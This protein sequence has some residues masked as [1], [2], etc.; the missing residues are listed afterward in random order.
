MSGGGYFA[1]LSQSCSTLNALNSKRSKSGYW[2][3]RENLI[4]EKID[5]TNR[6]KMN[7]FR[8]WRKK[9]HTVQVLGTTLLQ[10]NPTNRIR[11]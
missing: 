6:I 10:Y 5:I 4:M 3:N 9:I 2:S 1:L 11:N 7:I 8:P